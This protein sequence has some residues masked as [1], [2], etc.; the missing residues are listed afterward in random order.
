LSALSAGKHSAACA[1]LQ[2][3]GAA[4]RDASGNEV[5]LRGLNVCSLEF[6]NAGANWQLDPT[7]GGSVLLDAL[8]DPAK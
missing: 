6:D 8:A 2:V 3:D 1:R 5:R 7:D 4:L